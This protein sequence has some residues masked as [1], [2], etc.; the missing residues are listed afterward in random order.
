MLHLH[1]RIWAV[2]L[3]FVILLTPMGATAQNSQLP[4]GPTQGD[5]PA[6]YEA[7]GYAA[8][9]GISI[10]EAMRRF[11]LQDAAGVLEAELRS[12]EAA[13]F[14][15]LWLEHTPAFKIVVQFTDATKKDISPYLQNKELAA[16][17]EVRTATVALADLEKAQAAAL[18]SVAS[19]GIS[20]ESGINV[21]ENCVELYVV[22]QARLDDAVQKGKVQLSPYVK[23]IT[24][25]SMGKPDA[26]IYGGLSL[27][28]C[29]SGFAVKNSSGTK[30]ITTAA[31]C[32]NTQKYNGTSLTFKSEKYTGSYD[33]QW[34]TASG[35]TVKNKIRVSSSG[36]TRDITSTKSRS[37]QVV[38]GYVCKYGM[39]SGYTCGYISDK[40]YKPSYVPSGSATFIRVD[41]TAGYT[42]LS[43]AGD[44]GGPWF[45]V[46]TA[47]GTH[48]GEP[49][50]DPNDA[51]YM[52]VNYVTGINVSVMTAP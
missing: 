34:H 19:T 11:E 46:N 37:D 10:E 1:R 5:D 4:S 32:S 20:V 21:R 30:G 26:D 44:S 27:S 17:V 25:S 36:S 29:T 51:I 15:G 40:S 14:A 16:I 28:T 48:S 42:N 6:T 52:A 41:N 43:S 33:I 22:E 13:T 45:L 24:V 50:A 49:G 31:H 3:V 2:L 12:K 8:Q 39:T 9:L 35:Y 23:V 38:G 18:S 47:Y 7:K